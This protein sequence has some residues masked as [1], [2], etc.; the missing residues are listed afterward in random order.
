MNDSIFNF[1]STLA[2]NKYTSKV[3]NIPEEFDNRDELLAEIHETGKIPDALI[4]FECN[5]FSR[6]SEMES[7]S[8]AELVDSLFED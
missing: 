5:G 2:D 3:S 8:D 6:I 1:L 7:P 4:Y